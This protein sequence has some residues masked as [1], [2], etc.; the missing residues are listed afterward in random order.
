MNAKLLF[1]ALVVALSTQIS[2]C[3]RNEVSFAA[4]VQPILEVACIE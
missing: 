3:G 2:A 4:D 1:S